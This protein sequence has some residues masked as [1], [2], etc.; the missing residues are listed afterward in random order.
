MNRRFI[1]ILVG[2]SA[3]AILCAC[4]TKTTENVSDIQPEE[5]VLEPE[6][7][8]EIAENEEI[9]TQKET[10][11]EDDIKE[12][13]KEAVKTDEK[14]D[15]AVNEDKPTAGKEE[16]VSNDRTMASTQTPEPS[17]KP[18]A[19]NKSDVAKVSGVKESGSQSTLKETSKKETA[20]VSTA[21]PTESPVAAAEVQASSSSDKKTKWEYNGMYFNSAEEKRDYLVGI[22][23]QRT[24]TVEQSKD[25]LDGV[26]G[27]R[28]KNGNDNLE[29]NED[30]AKI[31]EERANQLVDDYSHN[32][33][34]SM[35]IIQW[36]G[37]E[38]STEE[39][40]SNWEESGGHNQNMNEAE[41][42]MGSA[43][44]TVTD[45]FGNIVDEFDIIVFE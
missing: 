37:G 13:P 23:N 29:W 12:E 8:D 11:S 28:E 1:T 33:A 2:I 44:A 21:S 20:A 9:I 41:G 3:F 6:S 26:N 25:M 32:G 35:E 16:A 34:V 5:V 38:V 15:K 36:N 14:Y 30:L 31:A 42:G 45:G 18:T 10:V 19:N 39:K 4:N 7:A 43:T 24:V 22:A 40:I 27:V 17:A